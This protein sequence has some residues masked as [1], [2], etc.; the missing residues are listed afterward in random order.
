MLIMHD[1][2]KKMYDKFVKVFKDVKIG[3]TE[4]KRLRPLQRAIRSQRSGSACK[5][6]ANIATA[7]GEAFRKLPIWIEEWF[8]AA[9]ES[10]N[11]SFS[12]KQGHR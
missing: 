2:L 4:F 11:V 1:T 7:S 9:E 3:L 8:D 10:F 6:C 5:V 12:E